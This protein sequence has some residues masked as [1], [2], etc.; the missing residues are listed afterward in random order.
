MKDFALGFGNEVKGNWEMACCKSIRHFI[1]W[2]IINILD[3]RAHVATS[4]HKAPE[5]LLF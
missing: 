5:N 1:S 4:M 2:V 3:M